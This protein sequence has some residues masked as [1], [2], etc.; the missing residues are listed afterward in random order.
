MSSTPR[1]PA[2]AACAQRPDTPRPR[3][4]SLCRPT[5]ARCCSEVRANGTKV[6]SLMDMPR[7][8]TKLKSLDM[9]DVAGDVVKALS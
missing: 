1:S 8:F 5:R 6:V 4:V 3:L 2:R 7:P 9:D